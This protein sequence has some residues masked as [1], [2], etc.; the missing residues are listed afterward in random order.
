VL[1]YRFTSDTSA[2]RAIAERASDA[3]GLLRA[4]G[5]MLRSGARKTI[6]GG[7]LAPLAPSTAA[8]YGGTGTSAVTAQAKVRSSY[9]KKLDQ[10]LR[11]KGS[12]DARADLKR[13]LSG[14]L[15]KGT[16]GNRTVDRL[17]RRLATAQAGLAIGAKVATG[18]K[19]IEKHKLLGKLAGA[20]KIK[21]AGVRVTVENMVRYSGVLN[22]GGT[23]G[24]GA[25]LPERRFAEITTEAR[26]IL[27]QMALDWLT[28]GNT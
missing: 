10:T 25:V 4:W 9:A 24:N 16:S 3:K 6:E 14:D 7:T 17:R 2:V 11:R 23:V 21:L 19:K 13:I 27:A 18:K 26:A 15:S 1:S 20:F 5:A 22:T 12:T 28:K 8:K